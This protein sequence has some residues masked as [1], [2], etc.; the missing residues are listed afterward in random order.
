MRRFFGR[1]DSWNFQVECEGQEKP[2]YEAFGGNF[3]GGRGQTARQ[4]ARWVRFIRGRLAERFTAMKWTPPACYTFTGGVAEHSR[5][6]AELQEQG[7]PILKGP[8]NA[9]LVGA[10]LEAARL[11]N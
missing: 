10:A 8:S 3:D 2:M 7:L 6:V 4:T 1:E 11:G 9:G 5:L